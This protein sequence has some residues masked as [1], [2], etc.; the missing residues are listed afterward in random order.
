LGRA[1]SGAPN[2]KEF[3]QNRGDAGL[4]AQDVY[5]S[6]YLDKIDKIRYIREKKMYLW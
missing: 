5:L 1:P 6:I 3:G 4:I 2:G